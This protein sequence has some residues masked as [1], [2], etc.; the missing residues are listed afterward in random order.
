MDPITLIVTKTMLNL[1]EINFTF[2]LGMVPTVRLTESTEVEAHHF[3]EI[4]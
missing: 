4:L 1:W 2:W 3:D